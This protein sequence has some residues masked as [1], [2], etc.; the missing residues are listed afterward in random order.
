MVWLYASHHTDNSNSNSPT[1]Y[2]SMATDILT[3]HYL[4]T[5]LSNATLISLSG[6]LRGPQC[7]QVGWRGI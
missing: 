2:D 4:T 7:K 5:E 1:H 3:H 6:G